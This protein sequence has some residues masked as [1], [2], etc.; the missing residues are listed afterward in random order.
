MR[1]HFKRIIVVDFEYEVRGGDYGLVNGDLPRVLCMAALELDANLRHV[2]THRLWRGEFGPKPPF[3]LDDDTLL[4]AYSAWAELTCFLTLGWKF[5]RHVFDLHVAY[6]ATSNLLLPYA[7]DEVRSRPGK[8][9]ADAC[10]AY[11]IPGWENIDKKAVARDIGEGNWRK[12]GVE[13]VFNYVE[14]D[15]RT[16]AELLRR[17]LR[18]HGCHRPVDPELVLHWSNYSGPTVAQIQARGMP[19][20]M[21]LWNEVQEHPAEVIDHLLRKFD[22]SYD[23]DEP[24]FSPEGEFSYARFE[25]WLL[26]TGA[27]FWPR[28]ES[29]KFDVSGD[30]FKLMA[31]I[32][33][34]EGIHALR[35]SLRVIANANLPIGRDGRNRPSLFAFGTT[36]GR[37]AHAKS[38]FNAHAGMRSFI[39]FAP[40]RVGLYLDYRTQEVGIAGALSGDER[41]K[42]AYGGDF[43]HSFA[44]DSGMT[45]DR[46]WKRWK[47]ENP[48]MR[49][50][51]KSLVLAVNYGM[52]VPSLALGLD[53][54]PL[55]ASGLIERHRQLYPRFWQ[56]REEQADNA[57][58][59]R[60]IESVFAWPLHI[61]TSP[62]RRTLYNF[63][64]QANGAEMLRLAAWKLCGAGLVPCMLVH[65]GILFELDSEAQ[66]EM[67]REIM[68]WAGREVCNGFE[69]DVDIDKRLLRGE[70]F[71]DKRPIAKEMWST[72]ME[73]LP[74]RRRKAA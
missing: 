70:P 7:P 56:W 61:A 55:I 19:V 39:T 46:D 4:V 5:P 41:L 71:Q 31:H 1:Q 23:S 28:L 32:P 14:E 54:H 67:A 45:R 74:S 27:P 6:L 34:V 10:R 37:N 57:M 33:G 3:D 73:A 65:D 11:G 47:A 58:F 53:R 9:L 50:R 30:A 16:E 72:I 48:A 69:I 13:Y 18:G 22:P 40:D 25:R 20:N 38:L 68:R 21:P 24:I 29:G 52:S 44:L 8:G 35:D 15:T 51:L 64:M 60:R 59:A 36:T 63:P 66:I 17:Q 62:N 43:Y 42:V 26:S 49:Q 2:R 12:Y